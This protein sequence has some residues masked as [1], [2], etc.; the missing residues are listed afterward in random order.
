MGYFNQL[1]QYGEQRFLDRCRAVGIDGLI[2][3]DLPVLEYEQ[4]Y[5]ELVEAAGLQLS[6]LISPQTSPERIQ[7]ISA[8]SEGFIYVVSSSSITGKTGGISAEQIAYFERIEAMQLP[9][10]RLIG[11]GISDAE[12]FQTACRYANGAIIGSAFIRA[13]GRG[14]DVATTCRDFV[15]G[16]LGAVPHAGVE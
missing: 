6:F 1:M 10:P 9:N 8:A 2:L 15:G 14:A 11:F 7:Q 12:S 5:R 4:H 13:L 3:P 16:I